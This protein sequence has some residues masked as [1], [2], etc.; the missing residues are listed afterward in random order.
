MIDVNKE[1][2]IGRGILLEKV[3]KFHY[4]G[5]MLD[6]N[7]GCDL[8]EGGTRHSED[9]YQCFFRQRRRRRKFSLTKLF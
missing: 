4:L 3:D 6:A 7:G 9:C 8:G 1:L 5:D 2:C